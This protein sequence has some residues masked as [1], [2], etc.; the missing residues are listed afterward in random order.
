MKTLAYVLVTFLSLVPAA[1]AQEVV[2]LVRHAERVDQS[3]DSP[4]SNAGEA[5]A[6]R[7]AATLRDAGLTHIFTTELART[8]QTAAP[9]A[10]ATHLTGTVVPAA[11]GVRLIAALRALGSRD[12]ALVVGHSNTLPAILR[13]LDISE[14]ISIGDAE[15]DN[16]FVI[17]LHPSAPATLVRIRY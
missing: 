2:Y 9:T 16:L 12:R 15:F 5:R 4:L 7:L 8:R 10:A 14:S 6:Q 1:T 11:D 3:A 13:G 17:A